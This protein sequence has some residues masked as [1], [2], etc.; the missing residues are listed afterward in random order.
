MAG[1]GIQEK[2]LKQAEKNFNEE[3]TF[4]S[5][6]VKILCRGLPETGDED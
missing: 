4:L 6:L 1:K 2:I 5:Q 3:T